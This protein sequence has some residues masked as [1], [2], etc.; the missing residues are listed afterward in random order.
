MYTDPSSLLMFQSG[1]FIN[2][3]LILAAKRPTAAEQPFRA[4]S[5]YPAS[6][7]KCAHFSPTHTGTHEHTH[8]HTHT[9]TEARRILVSPS[10]SPS[11]LTSLVFLPHLVFPFQST[12]IKEYPP[13]FSLALSI[14][15]SIFL[16]QFVPVA[17]VPIS[18][19]IIAR[20]LPASSGTSQGCGLQTLFRGILPVPVALIRLSRPLERSPVIYRPTLPP[21]RSARARFRP[22]FR[23]RFYFGGFSAASRLARTHSG[24]PRRKLLIASF[25]DEGGGNVRR[26]SSPRK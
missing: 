13:P 2:A 10:L 16:F 4:R 26:V 14:H 7:L 19:S 21:P 9:Y 5:R 12:P 11:S 1:S 23:V 8:T 22:L 25:L 18:I 17:R 3:S 20:E 24:D 15:P 6:L